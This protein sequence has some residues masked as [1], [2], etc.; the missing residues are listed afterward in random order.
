MSNEFNLKVFCLI[1]AHPPSAI[2][3]FLMTTLTRLGSGEVLFI[4]SMLLLLTKERRKGIAGISMLAGMTFVYYMVSILKE[5]VRMPRPFML[6]D[7]VNVLV[8]E[9]GFSFPSN[10]TAS[11]FMAAVILSSAFGR[12]ALFYGLAALVGISR[13]YIGVHFP[14][15]VLGGALVG[16]ITGLVL[17]RLDKYI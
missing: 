2:L 4:I 17:K 11:A 13:I 9:K 15:D 5:W 10:H 7:N 14:L 16:C 1:N 6:L 3:D 8:A 12:G